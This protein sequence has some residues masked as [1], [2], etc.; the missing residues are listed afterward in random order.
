MDA[1]LVFDE[2]RPYH[3]VPETNN[4]IDTV[5]S[6]TPLVTQYKAKKQADWQYDY[7]IEYDKE[8]YWLING[9]EYFYEVPK[10]ETSDYNFEF[11]QIAKLTIKVSNIDCG[12]DSEDYARIDVK[13]NFSEDDI[14]HTLTLFG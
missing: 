2:R 1:R 13:N 6:L 14:Y 4:L 8:K 11:T 12:L 5:F 10:G 9:Q 3:L 7:Y